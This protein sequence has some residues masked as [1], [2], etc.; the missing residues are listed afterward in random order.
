[1]IQSFDLDLK[2]VLS[3]WRNFELKM[4]FYDKVWT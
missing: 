2:D 4:L 1:M 3:L